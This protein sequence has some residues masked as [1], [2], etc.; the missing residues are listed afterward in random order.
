MAHGRHKG[1]FLKK[2]AEVAPNASIS[3]IHRQLYF[4]RSRARARERERERA[5]EIVFESLRLISNFAESFESPR[6]KRFAFEL[7]S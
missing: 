3:E 6:G 1:G 5:W 2:Y 7:H 4:K